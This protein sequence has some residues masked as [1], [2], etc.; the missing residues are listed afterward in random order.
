MI[1]RSASEHKSPAAKGR[2]QRVAQVVAQQRHAARSA[3]TIFQC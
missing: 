3:E 1:E 2:L